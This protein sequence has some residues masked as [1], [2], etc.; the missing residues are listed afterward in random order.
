MNHLHDSGTVVM[1]VSSINSHKL[2]QIRFTVYGFAII[3]HFVFICSSLLCT[4]PF[5][6]NP[7][8]PYQRMENEFGQK[9]GIELV[10]YVLCSKQN[11]WTE[12]GSFVFVCPL[13]NYNCKYGKTMTGVGRSKKSQTKRNKNKKTVHTHLFQC[14]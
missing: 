1:N 3:K 4:D 6:L 8:I 5:W 9:L 2:S 7:R 12:T 14:I 10:E 13:H 11:R